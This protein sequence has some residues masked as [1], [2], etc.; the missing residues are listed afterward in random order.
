MSEEQTELTYSAALLVVVILI[1]ATAGIL[2]NGLV[3]MAGNRNALPAEKSFSARA[4]RTAANHVEWMVVFAPLILIA[5]LSDISNQWTIL[6]A[7]LFFYGRLAHAPLYLIGLPWLRSAAWFVS[8]AG[9]A[10]VFLAL[11]GILA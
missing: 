5:A 1:H 9:V 4:K 7:Q 6:G 10:L 2:D 11:I 3:T 8:I